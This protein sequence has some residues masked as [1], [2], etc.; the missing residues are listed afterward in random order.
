MQI[1]HKSK[2]LLVTG[3][4]GTGKTT[5]WERY[6]LNAEYDWRFIFDPEGEWSFR[7]SWPSVGSLDGIQQQLPSGWVVFDPADEFEGE[8]QEG[9]DWFCDFVF[10]LCKDL[11]GTK[12]LATDELQLLTD[13]NQVSKPLRRVMETGR[14]RGLDVAF[15]SHQVNLMHN[16]TRNQF[17][18]VVSFNQQDPVATKWLEHFQFNAEELQQLQEGEFVLRN[19]QGAERRGRLKL[20]VQK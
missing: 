15:V 18:E 16:R 10:E 4:S 7:Q 8:L 5:F 1:S 3:T 13:S 17:T 12:L 14:R 2:K 20:G 19:K 11:P 9:F 6:I